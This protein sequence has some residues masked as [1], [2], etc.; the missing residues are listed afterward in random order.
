[1]ID[2]AYP[3]ARKLLFALDAEAAHHISMAGLRLAEKTGLLEMLSD[4]LPQV[5]PI[6]LMGLKFPS[7]KSQTP[8]VPPDPTRSHHQPHGFQ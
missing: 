7:W 6:E 1:M 3:L 2:A 4:P 5:K 8:F